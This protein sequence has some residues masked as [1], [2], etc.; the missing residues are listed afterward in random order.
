MKTMF[1][2]FKKGTTEHPISILKADGEE[3][4]M[5]AKRQKYIYLGYTIID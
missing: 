1:K 5:D 2:V 4:N 3:F